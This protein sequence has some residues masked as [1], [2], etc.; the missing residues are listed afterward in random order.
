MKIILVPKHNIRFAAAFIRSLIEVWATHIDITK[1]PEIIATLYSI[2]YGDPKT[3]PVA[4]KAG[5][6]I[7]EEFYPLA[8][9]W[10][11]DI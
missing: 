4:S 10:L 9:K 6:Q 5:V 11:T 3:N 8:K 2:G 1:R 7:I